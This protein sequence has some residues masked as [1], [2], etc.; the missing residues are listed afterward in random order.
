MSYMWLGQM[1]MGLAAGYLGSKAAGN[2]A[3]MAAWEKKSQIAWGNHRATMDLLSKN[4]NINSQA[5]AQEEASYEIRKEAFGVE[6]EQKIYLR[7]RYDNMDGKFSTQHK[8]STDMLQ[9]SLTNRNINGQTKYALD[10][11]VRETTKNIMVDSGINRANDERDIERTR[12]AKLNGIQ[13]SYVQHEKYISTP[14]E[15][16]DPAAMG[17]AAE[18][19]AMM[20]AVLN[21]GIQAVGNFRSETLQNDQSAWLETQ[22]KDLTKRTSE[23]KVET[24]SMWDEFFAKMN[25]G[26]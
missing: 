16:I 12:E 15:H 3:M 1:G 23:F 7:Y 10:R 20:G 4:R 2:E 6:A 14:G 8:S 9:M 26:M 22:Q 21:T 5:V 25:W 11:A 24:K 13:S 19:Q 17:K 18:K